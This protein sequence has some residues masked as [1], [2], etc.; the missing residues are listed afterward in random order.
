MPDPTLNDE[1]EFPVFSRRWGREDTYH[2]QRTNTGWYFRFMESQGPCDKSGRPLLFYNL[3]HDSIEYPETLGERLEWL[4]D[5]AHDE[6][7]SHEQVQEALNQLSQWLRQ[8]EEASPR[9]LVW[10]GLR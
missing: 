1:F 3:N 10:E 6:G 4:W 2:L 5:K 9:D 7:L 8:V